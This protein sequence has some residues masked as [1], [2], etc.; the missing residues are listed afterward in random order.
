MFQK[1]FKEGNLFYYFQKVP[2]Q[3]NPTENNYQNQFW[4][5]NKNQ[6]SFLAFQAGKKVI[7]SKLKI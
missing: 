3:I 7:F 6:N 5:K 2:K 4:E 1:N